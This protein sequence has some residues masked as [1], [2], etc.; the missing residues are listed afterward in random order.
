MHFGNLRYLYLLWLV[1]LLIIFYLYVFRR[2]RKVLETF[3][4]VHLLPQLSVSF[5]PA[6][7]KVKAALLILAFIFLAFTLTRPGWNPQPQKIERRGRDIVFLLDVSRSMLAEDLKPNRL[8]RAKIAIR[9][10][11]DVL[12]GDRVALIAFAGT[13]VVKCPL[14]LDYGFFRMALENISVESTSRGGTLI[15]DAIRKA[16][17]VFDDPEKKFKDIILITDGEDHDSFP[18]EAA[19]E[20]GKKGIRIIAVGLGDE[21]Q[22][23][24]IPI[25]DKFGNRTFLKYHGQEVW[26][27]LDGDTLRKIVNVSNGGKYFGVATGTIDLGNIYR[28]LIARAEKRELESRTI[29]RYQEKFQIFLALALGLL[30][31]EALMSER[32]RGV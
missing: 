23:Q 4:S 3:A 20:A 30:S 18:V 11:L 21:K 5:S 12:Q 6:R 15:G 31:L 25:T 13:A 32:K 29:R 14:T 9:D 8:E 2:K 10:V 7:Q 22:G 19:K 1:P 17:Q 28:Q 24:R 27:K 26:S 16:I